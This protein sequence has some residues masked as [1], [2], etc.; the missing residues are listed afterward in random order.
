VR[1]YISVD[2]GIG[3]NVRPALYGARYEAIAANKMDAGAKEVVTIAGRYCQ[4]GDILIRDISMPEL[5]PGDIIAVPCSGA[6]SIPMASNYNAVL[7]PAVVL[8]KE[9][10]A[11]LIRRRETYE[12]LMRRDIL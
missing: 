6:Y 7:K 3:D 4:S 12:D 2:G 5:E 8:V 11:R 10:K 1:K 9:G